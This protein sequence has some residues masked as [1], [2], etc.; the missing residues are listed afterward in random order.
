[1]RR[2]IGRFL[3]W[4]GGFTVVLTILAVVIVIVAARGKKPVPAK[5]LLEL[6][7]EKGVVENKPDDPLAR[8][9]SE[10]ASLHD[11]TFALERAE[12]DPR[13]AGLV[14]RLGSSPGKGAFGTAQAQELRDAIVRFRQKGKFA[15]AFAETFGEFSGGTGAYYLATAFDEIWLQP[16]GD[17]GLTGMYL[18]S[19]F[20]RGAFDKLGIK[21]RMDQRKEYKNAM[22]I[23]TEQRFTPAHREAMQRIGESVFSQ[24]V[25][26][27]AQG[28]KLSPDA[29]RQLI[30]RGPFLG[31]EAVKEKLV[32]GIAYRDEFYAKARERAGGAELLYLGKYLERAEAPHKKGK[33]VALIFGTGPVV[34]GKS[35]FDPFSGSS[36]MGSDTVAGAFRAAIT[37]KDVKA[38]LFRVDSPGGSYVASDAIWQEVNR[39]RKAGKPV[40]VSMGNVAGSGGYFVAMAADKIVAEPATITGSIGVLAGKLVLT[41]LLEGK[42]GITHDSVQFG[43][44]ASFWSTSRDY[45]PEEWARFQAWLD[46]IYE[47]FTTKVALGRKLDKAKVLEIAKGRIW[48]GEDA[49]QRGLVDELGGL[50][51]A[52]RLTK[53]LAN[54]PEGEDVELKEFP[55]EKSTFKALAAKLSGKE[56]DN[57]E[58]EERGAATGVELRGMRAAQKALDLAQRL[59]VTEEPGLLAAP[60]VEIRW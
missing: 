20:F 4:I 27:I 56:S 24:I 37:D 22:N 18:E 40:V 32:D 7:L 50:H 2:A 1:M 45:T 26:G 33:R 46:R 23:Y 12:N 34:R 41:E 54:I 49:K 39:A 36:T 6:D 60:E 35:D 48:S 9:S 3:M 59:G 11:I 10:R 53:Q 5:V 58:K 15:L 16:S 38:I 55:P 13:V 19:T 31:E 17:I 28:R 44:N 47:D 25:Q 8:L 42:L 14:A 29:V 43:K 30:D 57:S 52:L 21:P 51:T